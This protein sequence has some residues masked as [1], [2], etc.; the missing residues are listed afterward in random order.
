MSLLAYYLSAFVIISVMLID[1]F[2]LQRGEVII[3]GVKKC[4]NN[5]NRFSLHFSTRQQLRNSYLSYTIRDKNHPT[6]V[7]SGKSRTLDFSQIGTNEEYI[8]FPDYKFPAQSEW[9][10]DVKISS[11]SGSYIN[12]LYKIFPLVT[13]YNSEVYFD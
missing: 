6:T 3:Y 1:R 12:P 2:V 4:E 7:I 5:P 10:I 11:C 9:R 13:K 8:D